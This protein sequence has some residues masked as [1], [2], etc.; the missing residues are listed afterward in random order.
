MFDIDVLDQQIGCS[1]LHFV[2]F[3]INLI[4]NHW[5]FEIM[6]SF[7]ALIAITSWLV[8]NVSEVSISVTNGRSGH[9]VESNQCLADIQWF[10]EGFSSLT[11]SANN[12]NVGS[13]VRQLFDRNSGF[14]RYF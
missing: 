13:V 4:G 5:N 12:G 10:Y 11:A 14:D 6:V 1:C 2:R 3:C 9:S 8:A 7:V